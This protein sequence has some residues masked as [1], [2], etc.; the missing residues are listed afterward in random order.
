MATI[1][2]NILLWFKRLFGIIPRKSD[3]VQTEQNRYSETYRSTSEPVNIT[4][5]V[6]LK[7]SNI[8]CTEAKIEVRPKSKSNDTLLI[9][10]PRIDFLNT[11]LQRIV[12]EL[13]VITM[14]A[15]GIGGVIIKPYMY[16]GQIYTDILPQNRFF[17]VEKVG[18]I[19]RKAGFVADYIKN[20]NSFSSD[21]Y[22][23]YE[24]HTL[25]ESGLYVIENRAVK[26]S[27]EIP[28]TDVPDWSEIPPVITINGVSQML[29]AFIRCPIDNRKTDLNSVDSFYGVPVTFGQELNTAAVNKLLNE[30]PDEY[31]NKKAFI[32]ADD[33]LFNK[34]DKLPQS[35][36]YKLFRSGGRVDT[37]S[38][39]EVFSP[40]IRY[41]AYFDGVDRYLGLIEKSI[42]L[43][44]G[45]LTD[46][47]TGNATATEVKYGKFDTEAFADRVHKN[48]ETAFR[49]L[50]YAFNVFANAFN[51]SPSSSVDYEVN[52]DWSNWSEDSTERW[53]Q[54]MQGQSAGA[55]NGY[56]LRQY[57]FDEDKY[58]AVQNMP[59]QIANTP[60]L[61]AGE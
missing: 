40:E 18:K 5:V 17:V 52:F 3:I 12:E 39:W 61:L 44:R 26:N 33:L 41:M 20:D 34:D 53:A 8:V 25:D 46:L 13:D 23:R 42:G 27:I 21:E 50:V 22:I 58:T 45:I 32:G 59:E 24:Y 9:S 29:F 56:E 35:G 30:I 48:I 55:V 2:I 54:L 7:L 1:F 10:N 28:L 51:L 37:Q 43:N 60:P 6:A 14:R 57:I 15:L 38:F 11:T 4:A 49:Q 47:I 36:L 19:I 31:I 16:N